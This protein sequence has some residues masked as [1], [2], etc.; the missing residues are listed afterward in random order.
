MEIDDENME[1]DTTICEGAGWF[2]AE[3]SLEYCVQR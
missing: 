3:D 2:N 1:L